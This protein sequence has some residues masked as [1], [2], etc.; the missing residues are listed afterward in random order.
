M[1]KLDYTLETP[2]ERKAL[3][4]KILEENP[5]PGSAYLEILGDYL[6]LCM[7]KQEKKERKILTENRMATVNKR[8]TSFEGLVS[9]FENGEDGIYN[10]ITDNK[11]TI[12]QPKV[13]ITQK[14]LEEIPFLQ[15]LR[16]AI[17]YWET[18]LKKAQG[19]EAY[20]IKKTIIELRKDQYLVKNAYLKPVGITCGISTKFPTPLNDEVDMS[21]GTPRPHG[22]SLLDPRV[23]EAILCN[24]SRLKQDSEGVFHGDTWY[25]MQYFDEVSSRALAPHPLYERIVEYKIDGVQNNEIQKRLQQEFGVLRSQEYISSL[26]RKKI[27]ETI[28][29]AA[30]DDFLYWYYLNEEKGTYKRCTHCGEVKLALGKYFSRNNAA[31]DHLYTICKECRSRKRFEKMKGK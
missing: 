17:E 10:L 31:K 25:L 29:S 26:W 27:P 20:I 19:K 1:F 21:T 15:Q 11:H 2:E 13:S 18:Q 12:F 6:V 30:T 28:A 4:E 8:E 14:D 23:C 3:V 5:N 22:V 9:Q 24:Y 16:E 7:E